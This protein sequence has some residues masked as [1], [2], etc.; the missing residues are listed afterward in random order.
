MTVAAH[1][2]SIPTW[3]EGVHYRSKLEADWARFFDELRIVYTYEPEG[4]NFDGVRYL[5]DFWLPEL[6]TIVEVKGILD[7]LDV[8]KL[9]G[10]VNHCPYDILVVLAEAP[11][12]QK[13]ECIVTERDWLGS[14]ELKGTCGSHIFRDQCT[15]SQCDHCE[16]WWFYVDN[17]H[18]GCR[19]CGTYEGNGH[20]RDSICP[21]TS[22]PSPAF[23]QWLGETLGFP[24]CEGVEL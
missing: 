16:G 3:Y 6:K 14:L 21:I 15:L 8:R 2:F 18:W 23:L 11:A 24:D 4:F 7:E 13:F 12:G 1:K 10:L 5:P 19:R 22:P 20:I 9:K 17:G